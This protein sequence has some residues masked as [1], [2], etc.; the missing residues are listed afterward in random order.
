MAEPQL[1]A[2]PFAEAIA[3]LRQKVRLPTARSDDLH[4]RVHAKAFTVAGAQK[5]G[6]LADLHEAIVAARAG[7][8][9]IGQFRKAFDEIVTRHGWSYRGKRG[10][11]TRVIYDTNMTTSAMAGQ[12]QQFQRTA[13]TRPYLQ[14]Q[15][16]GD[17]RVRP[18]H[19]A[20][21]GIVRPIGDAFWDTHYPPNGWGCRCAVRSLSDAQMQRDGLEVSPAPAVARTERINVGTG[22][23]Y[24]KVPVGIDVGW[25][26]NVGKAW[27]GPDFALADAIKRLPAATQA[28]ALAESAT[29]SGLHQT[30]PFNVWLPRAAAGEIQTAGWLPAEAAVATLEA[31]PASRPL[32]V[33]AGDTAASL[34]NA[35]QDLPLR[36][37]DLDAVLQDG[38][39]LIAVPREG[40]VFEMR[41][42]RD[43]VWYVTGTRPAV[44]AAASLKPLFKRR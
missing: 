4:G 24:G 6:L 29:L 23:V 11:R 21:Q 1:G 33:V 30:A 18:Q 36:L 37:A 20:W 17:G 16:V 26:Y 25:D 39:T 14:Y 44:E 5:A 28:A 7:G 2:V 35:L 12:W 8:Q 41:P 3:H 27:L 42:G 15:T 22:E 32:I 31:A 19:R 38:D 13:G 34:G 10:W 40:A 43:G 9:S